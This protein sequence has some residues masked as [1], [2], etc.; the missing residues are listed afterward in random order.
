MGWAR[1]KN[2]QQPKLVADVLTIGDIVYVEKVSD[3]E[4]GGTKWELRQLPEVSGALIA[5]D[6]HTG[7]ILA[8]SGGFSYSESEFN[9]ATQAQRQPGSSFKPFVYAAAL[10]NG[11]TPSSVIM[12][13]PIEHDQGAGLGVWRPSNYSNEYYGPTTLRIGIEK[14][15]NVMTVRLAKDMG[16]KQLA[17]VAKRFGIYDDMPQVLSMALGAGETTVMKLTAAYGMLANGGKKIKPSLI[18]R[19]QDRY[20][21]NSIY[22]RKKSVLRMCGRKSGKDKMNQKFLKIGSKLLIH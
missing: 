18:D 15:R 10:E 17:N 19:V 22:S 8:L 14:S 6:P 2:R 21:A 3:E 16:M 5:L 11:Y 13:A 12:D 4:G 20:G 7:R 1:K 9:R